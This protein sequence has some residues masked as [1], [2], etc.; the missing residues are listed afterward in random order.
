[1]NPPSGSADERRLIKQFR[2]LGPSGR[3][4]LLAFA[5][6]LAQRAQPEPPPP[7]PREPIPIARPEHET[8]IGAIKRLS[9]TYE[10]LAR[11][12]LLNETSALMSAHVLRGRPASEVIDEL[13]ILFERHYHAYRAQL[14]A[15]GQP[16]SVQ[17]L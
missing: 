2:A 11:D 5:D 1:M 13:E 9:R 3:E 14:D 16:E 6:F 12:A 4:T 7:I 10:M 8:V 17:S 15:Q